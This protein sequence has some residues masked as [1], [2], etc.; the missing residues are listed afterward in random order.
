MSAE[1]LGHIGPVRLFNPASSKSESMT[2][3]LACGAAVRAAAEAAGLAAP[4]LAAVGLAAVG[5]AALVP[6]GSGTF[7]T[8]WHLGHLPFFPAKLSGT[9]NV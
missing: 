6:A 4:P 3:G 1:H 5:A 8:C 9:V 7:N 2:P